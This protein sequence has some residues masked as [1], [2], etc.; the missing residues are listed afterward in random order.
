MQSTTNAL[1]T[2]SKRAIQK[3]AEA[4]G[5]LNGSKIGDKI[6]KVSKPSP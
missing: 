3:T 2:T 6:A 1:K 5:D 4:T